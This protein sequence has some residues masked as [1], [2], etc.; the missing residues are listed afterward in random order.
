LKLP[1]TLALL[2]RLAQ[3]PV[4]ADSDREIGY[5]RCGPVGVLSFEFYNGAMSTGQCER[6]AAAVRT[7]AAADTRVLVLRGGPSFANGIHLNV[8]HAAARPE[9][10]AWRNIQ[11]IDDVCRE[12][13]TCIGQLVVASWAG[14]PVPVG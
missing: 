11:A 6:L 10:E 9:V 2:D 12:I 3:V 8:I 5:R 7:A 4:A 1:A 14:T 13:I